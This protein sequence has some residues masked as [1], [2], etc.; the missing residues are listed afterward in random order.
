[1]DKAPGAVRAREVVAEEGEA[2]IEEIKRMQ[3]IE[4]GNQAKRTDEKLKSLG[5]LSKEDEATL[6]RQAEEA[7]QKAME[8]MLNAVFDSSEEG[9][10]EREELY[11]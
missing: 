4:I 1:M 6:K 8:E 11:N 3:D 9:Q 5:I 10:G 2:A 7:Q